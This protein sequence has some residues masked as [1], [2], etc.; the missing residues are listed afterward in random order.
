RRDE[1]NGCLRRHRL[2]VRPASFRAIFCS[3]ALQFVADLPS[4]LAEVAGCLAPGGTFIIAGSELP[5][6]ERLKMLLGEARWSTFRAELPRPRNVRISPQLGRL[7]GRRTA[8]GTER[9]PARR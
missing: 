3:H 9:G 2:A 4:C 7:S 8:G 5:V 1:S 6:H